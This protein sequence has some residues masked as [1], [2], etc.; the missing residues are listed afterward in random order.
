M[1]WYNPFSWGDNAATREPTNRPDLDS[2]LMRFGGSPEGYNVTDS[3]DL[4]AGVRIAPG[5]GGGLGSLNEGG[6][7]FLG[8]S[9][10]PEGDMY[11]DSTEK[12]YAERYGGRYT[13]TGAYQDFETGKQAF[14]G[15]GKGGSAGG[16]RGPRKGE[17]GYQYTPVEMGQIKDQFHNMVQ[18]L[19]G[20]TADQ[21]GVNFQWYFPKW[22]G[23]WSQNDYEKYYR[24]QKNFTDTYS[25]ISEDMS[26]EDYNALSRKFN[27]HSLKARGGRPA[28]KE[29]TAKFIETGEVPF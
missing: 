1:A 2:N 22:Q 8:P 17:P 28:S 9:Y 27:M 15:D 29:E 25:G 16:G 14:R 11:W 6:E 10:G 13:P 7:A 20:L 24:G 18:G 21:L 23:G 12:Y 19:T 5:A 26:V 4:G 3:L